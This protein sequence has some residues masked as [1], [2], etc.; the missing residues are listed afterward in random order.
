LVVA[1]GV[2]PAQ[3]RV[4]SFDADGVPL[5]DG[6]RTFL[7]GTMRDPSDDWRRFD[8]VLAG[9]FNL[10]HSYHFE[11]RRWDLVTPGR[12]IDDWVREAREYL[13]L[14]EAAGVGVNLGLPRVA[15]ENGDA[16]AIAAAVNGVKDKA[17]LLF[18]TTWDEPLI[19]AS[20]NEL[21]PVEMDLA[22]AT[23]KNIDTDHPV[24]I[25]DRE[26]PELNGPFSAE[27]M[28]SGS[29][30]L[31][32]DRYAIA[33]TGPT[34]EGLVPV[35]RSF[36]TAE[37]ILPAKQV[38]SV[39][40]GHDLR[41]FF[42]ENNPEPLTAEN[43]QPTQEMLQ[44]QFH[45]S[46]ASGAGVSQFYWAPSD[47]WDLVNDSPQ[48]WQNFVDLGQD[49]AALMDAL[50]SDLPAA[51]VSLTDDVSDLQRDFSTDGVEIR[52]WSRETADAVYAGIV[53]PGGW[54]EFAPIG[55][56]STVEVS[57]EM[58]F[59]LFVAASVLVDGQWIEALTRDG[60]GQWVINASA[61][62]DEFVAFDGDSLTLSLD[63]FDS[64]V[65]RLDRIVPIP[66]PAV[67][68]GLWVGVMAL[69]RRVGE[70]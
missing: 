9:G 38:G 18:W 32:V 67:G 27:Q 31:L 16:A 50:N 54:A 52:S 29:D 45:L 6:E 69:R 59:E 42:P 1:T 56:D 58:P 28:W 10:T 36:E 30:L 3:A 60:S 5:I 66:E 22:Y 43:I 11:S 19:A 20:N 8:G 57:L 37:S 12:T 13:D 62:G 23:I 33:S 14:A 65:L 41:T 53:N 48:Q 39:M 7:Y 63:A 44:A 49:V 2:T 21:T 70:R 25:I 47:R 35:Y 4:V 34:E 64:A 68:L 17:A 51:S 61:F 40:Q 24:V 15:V 46:L 26:R 55:W